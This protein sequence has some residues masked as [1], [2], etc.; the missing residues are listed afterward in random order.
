[1]QRRKNHHV[2]Y[3]RSFPMLFLTM[4]NYSTADKTLAAETLQILLVLAIYLTKVFP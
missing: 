2:N 4:R 1:M 3:F